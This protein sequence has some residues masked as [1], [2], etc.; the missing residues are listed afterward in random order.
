MRPLVAI[1]QG[2]PVSNSQSSNSPDIVCLLPVG[3]GVG[4]AKPFDAFSTDFDSGLAEQL[5][6]EQAP[7]H[8]DLAMDA[9]DREFDTLRVERLLP[10][11][12]VLI[13]AVDKRA[14]EIKQEDRFD[15]HAISPVLIASITLACLAAFAVDAL[16]HAGLAAPHGLAHLE[17]LELRVP[18]VE[19]LVIAGLVMRRPERI[20]F[21][22]RFK[23]GAVLPDGVRGIKRVVVLR[24]RAFEQMKLDKARHLV[25]MTVARGPDLLESCLGAFGNAKAVHGDKH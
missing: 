23:H 25:Q 17:P 14:V 5:V 6:G 8:A 16:R 9:P 24:L 22:P 20:R 1:A 15:T 18:E 19:R 12:D 11:K 3:G 21:G 4:L 2:M 10:G 7:A 13:D